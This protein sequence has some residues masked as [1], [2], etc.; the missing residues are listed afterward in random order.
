VGLA[1][2]RALGLALA[3]QQAVHFIGLPEGKLALAELVL[4]LAAAPKSNAV[5][6][7]Y[8]AA[9]RDVH[10]GRTGPVP[11]ALRNAPTRLMKEVGYGEGYEY[12]PDLEEAVADLQ[13]LPDSLRGVR[14]YRPGPQGFERTQ[15]ERMA[16]WERRREKARAG[17]SGRRPGGTPG[18]EDES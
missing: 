11:L 2:P 12:A 16:F 8:S 4:Y 3:A 6:R 9:A 5:Y 17:P 10:R 13:C 15:A 18:T 7:A 1:D 14:Y